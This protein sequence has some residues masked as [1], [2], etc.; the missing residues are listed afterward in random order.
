MR[1]KRHRF[2]VDPWFRDNGIAIG[3]PGDAEGVA[4]L[5]RQT[6]PPP[7]FTQQ[8]V[9]RHPAPN[10]IPKAPGRYSVEDWGP[11]IDATWGPS[12]LNPFVRQSLFQNFWAI[13][14]EDFACF[15]D[16][17]VDWDG[18]HTRY[19]GEVFAEISRGRFSAI[20]SHMARELQEDP[21][22]EKIEYD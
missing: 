6:D 5:S 8:F 12:D 13:I 3:L 17:D 15:Q 21:D 14:D 1:W 2:V 9:R 20:L 10:P 7:T 11:I 19:S 22:K 18:V 4:V 16:L